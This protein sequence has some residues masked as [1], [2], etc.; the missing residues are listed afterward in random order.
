MQNRFEEFHAKVGTNALAGRYGF[1]GMATAYLAAR[2]DL[3]CKT[4]HDIICHNV[5]CYTVIGWDDKSTNH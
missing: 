4:S 2:P 5:T 3:R 1:I